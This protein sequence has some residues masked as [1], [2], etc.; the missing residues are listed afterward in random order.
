VHDTLTLLAVHAHPDDEVIC[1][2]GTFARYAAE[3]LRTALVCCTRGEE[4][5]IHDPAL[6]LAEAYPRLGAIREG[7]LRAAAR[8]LGIAAVHVL[9]YRDSGL[10][11]NAN[12]SNFSNADPTEAAERLAS[13]VR[14]LR[15][16][17]VVT[18]DEH[19]GYGH[20]DHAMAHS[21]TQL[22]ITRAAHGGAGG[23]GWDVPKLYYTAFPRSVLWWV[24]EQLQ[25]R[26]LRPPFREEILALDIRQGIAPDEVITARVDVRRYQE[27]VRRALCAHRTQIRAD[28]LLLALPGDIAAE[29]F[30][31]DHYIRVYTRVPAPDQEM[32]LFAGLR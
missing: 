8:I 12:P 15:P 28:D 32:D 20:P 21:V 9:G 24:N 7:E 18:Y 22:A 26:S 1:M 3:G 4:G 31:V 5:T 27:Q 19:G 25:A 11:A 17:V 29:A 10:P 6:D 2:G 14:A 13:I 30:A 16:H 23:P